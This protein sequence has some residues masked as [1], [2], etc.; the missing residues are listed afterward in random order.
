VRDSR[1][2]SS[3]FRSQ[4]TFTLALYRCQ[5]H[6]DVRL[7]D[8]GPYSG[9][10]QIYYNGVW[11]TVCDDGF[12]AVDARVVCRQLG[13]GTAGA[14]AVQDP[15]SGEHNGPILLDDV[16]CAGTE[17]RLLDCNHRTIGTHNCQHYEDVRVE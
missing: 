2:P 1:N 7:I 15:T 6:A 3:T 8:G 16:G 4:L 13:Y 10:L 11:G 14:N 5:T 17:S 12:T 9:L